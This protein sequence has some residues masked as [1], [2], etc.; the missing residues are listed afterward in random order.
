MA[1]L[2]KVRMK[3]SISGAQFAYQAG[4]VV[5]MDSV[6]AEK[7]V[8]I[9]DRAEYVEKDVQVTETAAMSADTW[10]ED[11]PRTYYRLLANNYP[12]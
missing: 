2:V 12:M 5:L 4:Q 1:K 10:R 9:G 6:L 11:D 7:L 8:K 3:V